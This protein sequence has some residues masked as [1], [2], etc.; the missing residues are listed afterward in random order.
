M[1]NFI[2]FSQFFTK[3]IDS[4]ERNR[5]QNRREEK[6][7]AFRVTAAVAQHERAHFRYG[8]EN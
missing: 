6:Q 2:V 7:D 8:A 5:E 1:R 4:L 3:F